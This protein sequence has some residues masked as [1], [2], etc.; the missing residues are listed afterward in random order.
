MT[1]LRDSLVVGISKDGDGI[2]PGFFRII[3][4]ILV[5]VV[6][7][8]LTALDFLSSEDTHCAIGKGDIDF[9][10]LDGSVCRGRARADRYRRK[11][12]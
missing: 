2:D 1:S 9:E 8:T 11:L 6:D 3:A 5:G 7:N 12:R 4:K 10:K